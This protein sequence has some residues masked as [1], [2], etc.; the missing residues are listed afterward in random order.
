MKTTLKKAMSGQLDITAAVE[1]RWRQTPSRI[2]RISAPAR[3]LIN[4]Q[5]SSTH[6]VMEINGKDAPGLLYRIT[7]TIADLGVQIQTA[8]VSTYGDR[9][10][11]VFY[12]KDSFGLKIERE[13]RIKVIRETLLKVLED[14]DP[15]N[16][17]AA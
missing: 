13:S 11:D 14:S 4:N 10:V 8:S 9:V 15:A 16:Q 12:V 2:R 5:I 1:A 6:T 3:V 17:V 7:R